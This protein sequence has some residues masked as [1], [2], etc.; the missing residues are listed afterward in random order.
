MKN[1]GNSLYAMAPNPE[2]KSGSGTYSGQC[3]T[4]PETD[5]RILARTSLSTRTG[6]VNV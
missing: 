4:G 5:L 3:T 2:L 6:F 1:S